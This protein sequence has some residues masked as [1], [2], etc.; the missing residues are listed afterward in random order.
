MYLK[1]QSFFYGTKS[2]DEMGTAIKSTLF[3]AFGGP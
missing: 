3:V 2:L 1:K